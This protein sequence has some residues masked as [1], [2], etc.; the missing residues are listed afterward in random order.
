MVNF[1][2]LIYRMVVFLCLKFQLLTLLLSLSTFLLEKF[3]LL[4][5]DGTSFNRYVISSESQILLNLSGES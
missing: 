1:L 3:F 5:L 4:S 2:H